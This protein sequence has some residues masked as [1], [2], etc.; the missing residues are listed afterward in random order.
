MKTLY[1]TKQNDVLDDVC[2]RHYILNTVLNNMNYNQ[3]VNETNS[4]ILEEAKYMLVQQGPSESL[5]P[6][7]DLVLKSNP[8]LLTLPLS[9][10]EG[11]LIHLPVL[12]ERMVEHIE[13][14][15]SLWD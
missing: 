6:M 3:L 10:P 13:N 8:H 14:V 2:W 1:R 11:V 5:D 7:I 9:L 12:E 15:I 4:S